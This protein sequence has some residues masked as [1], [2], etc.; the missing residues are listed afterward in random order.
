MKGLMTG[1]RKSLGGQDEM[2]HI[3]FNIVCRE[4]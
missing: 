2:V 3:F 4:R 1:L